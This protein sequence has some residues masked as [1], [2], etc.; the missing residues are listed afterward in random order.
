[1]PCQITTGTGPL[2]TDANSAKQNKNITARIF[3]SAA[4]LISYDYVRERK[5]LSVLKY[6]FKGK[7]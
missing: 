7:K 6:F 1:M 4:I 5:L 2:D 3:M